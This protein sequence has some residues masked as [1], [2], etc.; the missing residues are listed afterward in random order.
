MKEMTP[1]DWALRPLKRYAQFRGRA[2]RAEYWWFYLATLVISFLLDAVEKG[3][4][5][6][7]A[8]TGDSG[9]LSLIFTAATIITWI[10]VSVRRL[11]DIDLT[12]WW[13][14]V[15]VVPIIMIAG[16]IGMQG[17]ETLEDE[18]VSTPFIVSGLAFVAA[19]FLLLIFSVLPGTDGPNRYGAD[20]YGPDDLEEVFA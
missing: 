12:G 18:S 10:A 4:D 14:M 17:F 1:L 11:H 15:L 19:G 5:V 6:S 16:S 20:P 9:Y 13:L 3:F 8:A 2:P 7:E